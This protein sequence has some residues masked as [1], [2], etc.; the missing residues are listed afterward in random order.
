[1]HDLKTIKAREE[2]QVFKAREEGKIDKERAIKALIDLGN[3]PLK[4]ERAI[5]GA[6]IRR[7][8]PL[9]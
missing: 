8:I 2:Q 3:D 4:A 5:I 1:M 7:E 9:W 6:N